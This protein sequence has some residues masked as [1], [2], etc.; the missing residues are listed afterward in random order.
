MILDAKLKNLARQFCFFSAVSIHYLMTTS[1][2]QA[3]IVGDE[4][5]ST[6]VN[7]SDELDFDITGGRQSGSNLFHSF[8]QFSVPTGGSA[9]FDNAL[10][11][12]NI[13]S[14]VTGGSISNIDGLIRANGDASLFLLNPNGIIFGSN[15]EL[16]IGGSFIA[17]TAE[18]I[19]FSDNTSF[20]TSDLQT[21][22]L[23]TVSIPLGLQFGKEAR[24]IINRSAIEDSSN[25]PIGL[26]VQP[27]KTLALIGGNISLKSG[28]LSAPGGRIELG[29][30]AGNSFVSLTPISQ[31]WA[32]Q[33]QNVSDF[34]DIQLL[35]RAFVQT[36]GNNSGNII[37]QGKQIAIANG[38][39]IV[40][41]NFGV[42][43]GGAIIIDAS[44]S[45]EITGFSNINS[46]VFS[47]GSSDEIIISAKQLI[48]RDRSAIN[49]SSQSD[50]QGGNLTIDASK[51]V[52][53]DGGRG[54]SRLTTQTIG[55]RDAGDLKLTTEKLILRNGG[56][57]NSSTRQSGGSGGSITI[58]AE[59]LVEVSGQSIVL[60]TGEI[61][62]S[63]LFTETR[64]E[65]TFGNGGNLSINTNLLSVRDGGITS[66]AAVEGSTGRAGNLEINAN[67]VFLDGGSITAETAQTGGEEGANINIQSNLLTLQNESQISATA[68]GL[69][70][71]GNINIDA[72][73]II[74]FPDRDNDIIARAS[75]GIGGNI[76][77][78][79]SGIFGI[80]QRS[81]TP[82]NNTNDIDPSSDFGL[83]GTVSINELE[84]NPA[85]SLED[86]PAEIIDVAGLVAQNLCQ[87][88]QGSEFVVTGKGGIAA[89]PS[90]SRDGS[91][92]EVDL[93]E[94][95]EIQKVEEI[96]KVDEA[97]E[98]NEIV[99][100]RGWV[101]GDRGT[102][103]LVAYATDI[104]NLQ[105]QFNNQQNCTSP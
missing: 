103:E 56:Q 102:I 2:S 4:T 84:V 10:D 77:I 18:K 98:T 42:D 66:V 95:V 93:V 8:S 69:A 47:V 82:P 7:I 60:E 62:S 55:N 101:V 85:E 71:G 17:T 1:L 87:Q 73:L 61:V 23:L 12:Q 58:N 5:L 54:V 92:N 3:Q 26:Q 59:R 19:N 6:D 30:V 22:S 24:S 81:S 13:F 63:G 52:E 53:V 96:E 91:V 78:T 36:R 88:G 97:K 45:V 37:L 104:S 105:S 48:V 38:S 29:S 94:P 9:T 74:A 33:Y 27:A 21:S 72:N 35:D 79:T 67:S 99:E 44:E 64:G 28:N 40:A 100:A 31:G 41:F 14:R 83:D 51:L 90:Q 89:S 20:G 16:N 68:S 57:I 65:T 49:T 46:N 75:E 39:G 43:S 34:Q 25:L 11:V 15:A 80:Q 76:D 32:F 86:L 50:G 70:N